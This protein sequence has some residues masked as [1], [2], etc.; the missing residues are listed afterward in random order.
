M[1][2]KEKSEKGK[3][4]LQKIPAVYVNSETIICV[5]K[6]FTKAQHGK[7]SV[8]FDP[9]AE[10]EKLSRNIA[11]KFNLYDRVPRPLECRFSASARF[12]SIRFDRLVACTDKW[13]SS[14]RF[15]AGSALEKITKASKAHCKN[16]KLI[17]SL[18]QNSR[19]RPG[20]EVELD[21]KSFKN[22]WSSYTKH[23]PSDKKKVT[24][25]LKDGVNLLV[26]ISGPKKV[27]MYKG[28]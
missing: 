4:S 5:L 10:N 26:E 9:G 20:E 11:V 18:P 14:E 15:I 27:G 13:E 6:R 24:C 23:F 22:K 25:N 17:I 7:I 1:I 21:L 2:S 19:L 8:L 28:I 12:I 3:E 16:K